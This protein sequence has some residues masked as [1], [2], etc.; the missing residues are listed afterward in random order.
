MVLGEVEDLEK[1]IKSRW[2]D[3]VVVTAHHLQPET[4]AKLMAICERADIQFT[5]VPSFLEILTAQSQIYDVAGIPVVTME[6]RVFQRRNRI[7]K[8]AMD[9]F[10]LSALF[11]VTSPFLVPLIVIVIISIKVESPGPVLFRQQRVG[12]GGRPI[13]LFKFRS[14]CEDA[15]T[16]KERLMH[17]NEVKGALFKIKEDPRMTR[18]GK[19][20][21]RYSIDE[22][23]QLINVLKGQMSLVGPRPPV[24]EEAEKYEEWQTK[25]FDLLP[26]M[27]G[28][29]QVSGRSDL[30]FDE[31]IRLDLYYIENW[32][33]L[34]DLKIL[35]KAIPVVFFGRGAY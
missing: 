5:M 12:K 28:L 34:L 21:R 15:E 3:Q 13:M 8:R 20:I 11:L 23:P 25:R 9:L 30:T 2:I 35:L 1:L 10:L 14:M 29:P 33:L 18:V 22:L 32:S 16:L 24:P 7:L 4:V 17:L 26:G 31:V 6:E 19:F 27:V